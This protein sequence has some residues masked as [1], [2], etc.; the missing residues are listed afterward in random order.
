[1]SL[2][3]NIGDRRSE[4]QALDSLGAVAIQQHE[5]AEATSYHQQ[6]LGMRRTIGD[7]A[8]EGISL[9]NLARVT[10]EAGDYGRAQKHLTDSLAIYQATGDR[11]NEIIAW[12]DLAN[13]YILLGDLPTAQSCLQQGLALGREIGAVVLEAWVLSNL[14]LVARDRGELET[15]AEVL[16]EGLSLAHAH[17]DRYLG[18]YFFSYLAT[19]SL[20][21]GRL[22]QAIEQA[23]TALAEREESQRLLTADDLPT[24]AAAHMALGHLD[25]A[26]DYARQALTILDECGGVGPEFALRDHFVCYQVLS[27]AGQEEEAHTALQSAY[28]LLMA[29]AEKITDPALRQSFLARVQVNREIV[30]EYAKR[31]TSPKGAD[32]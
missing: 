28:Y 30:E 15:A 31:V 25:K 4:A 5:F 13:L 18:S 24:L 6:A 8:G 3:R 12:N 29:R 1:M 9:G 11:W 20:I 17:G 26:A 14:G 2:S 27:A 21:T 19:V 23:N 7:R 32:I 10:L 22:E 16:T